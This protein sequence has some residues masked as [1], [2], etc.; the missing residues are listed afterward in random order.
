MDADPEIRYLAGQ[1]N[2]LLGRTHADHDG[3]TC[4]DA[5]GMGLLYGPVYSFAKP[6][7]VRIYY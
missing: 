1:F 3:C 4:Q 2:S 6:E 5:I 7:V